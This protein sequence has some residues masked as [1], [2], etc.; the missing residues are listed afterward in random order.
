MKKNFVLLILCF[1]S[2]LF[3]PFSACKKDTD[4]NNYL[5]GKIDGVPFECTSNIWSTSGGSGDKIIALNGNWSTNSSIYIY[6]ESQGSNITAG[7]Y[8]FQTGKLYNAI[9]YDNNESYSAGSICLYVIPCIFVGSGKI[10]FLEISK[11][12]IKGT[13]EFVTNLGGTTG[14]S[15]SVSDGEFYINR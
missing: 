7:S 5:R 4:N 9:L 8:N 10:N 3:G 11:K 13:F 15:K 14:L 6:L 2:L 1:S 12:H